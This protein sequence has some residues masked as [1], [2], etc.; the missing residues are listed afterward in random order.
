LAQLE[1]S[2]SI[3]AELAVEEAQVAV[4]LPTVRLLEGDEQLIG[5]FPLMTMRLVEER[6]DAAED[7]A[8]EN[9]VMPA[10]D[11]QKAAPAVDI[12]D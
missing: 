8:A 3:V 7:L 10:D 6:V 5:N 9:N 12:G 1:W 4:L 11:P 2:A